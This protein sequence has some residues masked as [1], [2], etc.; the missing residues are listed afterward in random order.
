[1]I[2]LFL[3]TMTGL[4]LIVAAEIRQGHVILPLIAV[5]LTVLGAGFAA[6]VFRP[7]DARV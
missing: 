1:M 6:R 5:L 7:G 3:A 2:F 4:L